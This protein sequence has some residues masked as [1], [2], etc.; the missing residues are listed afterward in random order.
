MDSPSY[1]VKFCSFCLKI[2]AFTPLH[3]CTYEQ[4]QTHHSDFAQ[5]PTIH[6]VL[7]LAEIAERVKG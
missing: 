7:A 2:P 5:V 3:L 4:A 1:F 6:D